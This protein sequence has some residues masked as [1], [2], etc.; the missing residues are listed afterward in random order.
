[1]MTGNY[2]T[3]D[4]DDAAAAAAIKNTIYFNNSVFYKHDINLKPHWK[5]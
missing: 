4:D 3:D 5:H 2:T 1:M